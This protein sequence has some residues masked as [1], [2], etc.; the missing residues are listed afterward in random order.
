MPRQINKSIKVEP[1]SFDA[2]CYLV[3]F[4]H[5][6]WFYWPGVILNS[7]EIIRKFKYVFCNCVNWNYIGRGLYFVLMSMLI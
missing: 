5:T 3:E 4:C 7:I 6:D 2:S 1:I